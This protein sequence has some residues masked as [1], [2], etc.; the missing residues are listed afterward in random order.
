ME[1]LAELA[2]WFISFL[3]LFWT[4]ATPFAQNQTSHILT[5]Y[6]CVFLSAVKLLVGRHEEH[7]D[8]KKLSNEVL[9]WLAGPHLHLSPD[10]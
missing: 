10:G 6:H 4:N 8:G 1:N 7:Q 3:R 9:A 2:D 5:P